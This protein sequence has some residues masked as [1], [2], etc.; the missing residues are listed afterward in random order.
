M[1]IWFKFKLVEL[2]PISIFGNVIAVDISLAWFYI[3]LLQL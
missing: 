1:L 3:E 2:V